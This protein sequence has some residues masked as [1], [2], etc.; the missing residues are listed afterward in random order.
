M[1]ARA[2]HLFVFRKRRQGNAETLIDCR[3][4]LHHGHVARLRISK[5]ELD[6][7]IIINAKVKRQ[8]GESDKGPTNFSLSLLTP[9]APF[10]ESTDKLIKF[11]GQFAPSVGPFMLTGQSLLPQAQDYPRFPARHIARRV[12]E[13]RLDRLCSLAPSIITSP[14][15]E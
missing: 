8:R 13:K 4:G 10:A 1:H 6:R 5:L 7:S 3:L 9:E 14:P 15:A 11:V 2:K 12:V